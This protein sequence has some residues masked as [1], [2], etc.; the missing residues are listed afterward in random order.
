MSSELEQ[1]RIA[2]RREG[3]LPNLSPIL[4]KRKLPTSKPAM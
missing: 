1:R 2:K 4:P 3:F